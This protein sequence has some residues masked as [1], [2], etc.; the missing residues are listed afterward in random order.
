[1]IPNSMIPN[2][3]RIAELATGVAYGDC[4]PPRLPLA[5]DRDV[6]CDRLEQRRRAEGP[7]KCCFLMLMVVG[8]LD[9]W[10]EELLVAGVGVRRRGPSLV[11]RRGLFRVLV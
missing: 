6:S 2:S 4:F 8:A 1:M 11:E 3:R 9:F 7:A 10:R 5:F